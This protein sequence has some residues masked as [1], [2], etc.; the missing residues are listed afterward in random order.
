MPLMNVLALAGFVVAC[1][2]MIWFFRWLEKRKR[3]RSAYTPPDP[4]TQEKIRRYHAEKRAQRLAGEPRA[5]K[6]LIINPTTSFEKLADALE[7][8]GYSSIASPSAAEPSSFAWEDDPPTTKLS[9][10]CDTACDL[11]ILD[12]EAPQSA[13]GG[14]VDGI[15]NRP[16]LVSTFTTYQLAKCLQSEDPRALLRGIRGGEIFGKGDGYR[17]FHE[18]VAK[19]RE[20][21]D[22]TIAA[23]ATRIEAILRKEAGGAPKPAGLFGEPLAWR[24]TG[25]VEYPY[26]SERNGMGMRLRLGD[27]PAEDMYTLLVAMDGKD[28]EMGSFNDW[29]ADWSKPG[30]P[31][32]AEKPKASPPAAAPSSSLP[33]RP[34]G[35]EVRWESG[36]EH[37]PN[38]MY[39][40]TTLMLGGDGKLSLEMRRAGRKSTW[41]GVAS[42][43]A[44][45]KLLDALRA[46]SFPI[47]PPRKGTPGVL[48]PG[49]TIDSLVVTVAGKASSV[50]MDANDFRFH[51]AYGP[52]WTVLSALMK[53]VSGGKVG[54]G[55]DT[56]DDGA[57]TAVQQ[58]A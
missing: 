42:E 19:L 49:Q 22:P 1:G 7:R 3:A 57:I 5:K 31:A 16:A 54:Y 26:A 34:D 29:P 38:C 25:D 28:V 33:D 35:V 21:T 36:M 48:M 17:D 12:V 53:R 18:G 52:V 55:A 15:V 27:F 9:Y 43:A 56:L 41:E 20:H 6:R 44:R 30:K 11:R 37:A 24:E 45:K 14:A 8:A 50:G 2:G 51:A 39:G 46:A 40:K 32:N 47:V 58:T 13:L 4:A 10:T 23:E